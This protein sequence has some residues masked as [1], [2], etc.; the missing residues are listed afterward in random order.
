MRLTTGEISTE[1]V[2]GLTSLA[3]DQLDLTT[4]LQRWR[5][6][7]AIENR[8]H[9]VKD[10][11]LKEDASRMRT[12]PAPLIFAL[13]RNALVTCL[14]AAGFDSVTQGRRH[15]ALNLDNAISCVCGLSE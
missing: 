13:L 8:L 11:V 6:H 14:H 4:L 15:L 10:V 5:G 3:P 12:G 7:W 1:R 9:W 2:Y